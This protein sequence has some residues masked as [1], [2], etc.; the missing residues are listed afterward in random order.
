[1]CV[2]VMGGGGRGAGGQ[3]GRA[4]KQGRQKLKHFPVGGM[5]IIDKC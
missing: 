2:C 1:M 5:L 3:A 4:R